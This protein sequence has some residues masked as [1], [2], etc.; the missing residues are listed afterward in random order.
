MALETD[1]QPFVKTVEYPDENEPLRL[2]FV[3]VGFIDLMNNIAHAKAIDRIEPGYFQRYLVSLANESG[4]FSLKD[5]PGISSQ[6]YCIKSI[7][8]WQVQD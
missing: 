7:F 1:V 8:T 3:S 6:R 2:V 4:E 5:L